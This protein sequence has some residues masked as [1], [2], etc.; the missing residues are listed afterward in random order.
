MSVNTPKLSQYI[1]LYMLTI[2]TIDLCVC[3]RTIVWVCMSVSACESSRSQ[4]SI[5]SLFLVLSW[6]STRVEPIALDSQIYNT[7][8]RDICRYLHTHMYILY[9][10]THM[11]YTS[12]GPPERDLFLT[13]IY[14]TEI[15]QFVLTRS[16]F[17]NRY[18]SICFANVVL[19]KNKKKKKLYVDNLKT[20]NL[21]MKEWN[22]HTHTHKDFDKATLSEIYFH[23][24][25]KIKDDRCYCFC[26]CYYYYYNTTI[27]ESIVHSSL[28]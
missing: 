3:V 23:F 9:T 14:L 19:Y 13:R 15:Y 26:F 17:I 21:K 7:H 5:Q 4:F 27:V 18:R 20:K 2:Y 10:H 11:I 16:I 12:A 6:T 25:A 24:V 1:I 22:T 28:V 8:T